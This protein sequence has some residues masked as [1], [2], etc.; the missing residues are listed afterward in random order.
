MRAWKCRVVMAGGL[1]VA[2][3]ATVPAG[4]SVMVLPGSGKSFDEFRSEDETCRQWAATQSGAEPQTAAL[5][6]T[7]SGAALGTLAGAGLGAAVGAAA[8]NPGIGAAVGAGSGLLVGSAAGTNAGQLAG[9]TLQQRYDMSYQQCMYASGNQI[10]GAAQPMQP[11]RGAHHGGRPA[12]P[13]P[14]PPPPPGVG[15]PGTPIT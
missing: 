12:M 3:C 7:A 10:P 11:R 13:P 9:N 2:G 1:L 5:Q 4:P 6:S 14:P 15:P 8:G